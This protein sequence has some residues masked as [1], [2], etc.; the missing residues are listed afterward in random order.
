MGETSPLHWCIRRDANRKVF[1]QS[2]FTVD[3]TSWG[4]AFYPWTDNAPRPD[5]RSADP[6]FSG[7]LPSDVVLAPNNPLSDARKK[8]LRSALQNVRPRLSDAAWEELQDM[9][10]IVTTPRTE[11]M[12][13]GYGTLGGDFLEPDEEQRK[14]GSAVC[15]GHD[16]LRVTVT[17]GPCP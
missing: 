2:K 6:G 1:V 10:E 8:E 9:V 13:D 17:P 12:P 4:H 15:Q 3:D 7:L 14:R 11:L 5:G 16:C